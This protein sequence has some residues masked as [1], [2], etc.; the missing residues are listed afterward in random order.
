[1]KRLVPAVWCG[2]TILVFFAGYAIGPGRSAAA[3][4]TQARAQL[5]VTP[6]QPQS[7]EIGRASCRERV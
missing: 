6:G 5:P 2:T 1:M 3:G 4:Q 7:L